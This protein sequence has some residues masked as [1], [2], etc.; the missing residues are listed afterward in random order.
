MRLARALEEKLMDVRLR[1][2]LLGE[3]KVTK[4]QVETYLNSLS[5]DASKATFTNVSK[6]DYSDS[7]E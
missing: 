1:D 2:K 3:G 4:E 7:E 6:E 5:D